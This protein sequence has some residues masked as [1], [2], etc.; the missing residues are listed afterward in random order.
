LFK[1]IF[2]HSVIRTKRQSTFDTS[3]IEKESKY[4]I[5]FAIIPYTNLVGQ[6][7]ILLSSA[8]LRHLKENQILL[9]R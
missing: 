3:K 6:T 2:S 8:I 5:Y 9:F 4:Y 1:I 7:I